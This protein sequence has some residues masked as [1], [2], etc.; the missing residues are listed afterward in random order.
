MVVVERPE[1]SESDGVCDLW[2][3]LVLRGGDQHPAQ[4][5]DIVELYL[6]FALENALAPVCDATFEQRDDSRHGKTG[7]QRARDI[8]GGRAC[9]SPLIR[10][11]RRQRTEKLVH[12][13]PRDVAEVVHVPRCETQSKP[14]A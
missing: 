8:A 4:L 3:G 14:G 2:Y 6:G 12:F 10:L 11:A 1:L 5:L 13:R 9:F 7:P